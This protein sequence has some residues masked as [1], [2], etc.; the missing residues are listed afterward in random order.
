MMINLYYGRENLNKEQFLF[1]EIKAQLAEIRLKKGACEKI[2]LLVPD[3]FTLQAERNAF[4]YLKIPGMLE[5]EITSISRLGA[6]ILKETGG[7]K[8]EHVD[9]YGRHMLLSQII[10]QEKENLLAF[11][12]LDQNQSFIK[13]MNNLISEMK[14]YNADPETILSIM[15]SLDPS[16]LLNKKLKDIYNIYDK[17]ESRLSGKQLD[18]EDYIS[19]YTEGIN[20]SKQLSKSKIWIFGFDYFTPKN[21]NVLEKL[22]LNTLEVNLIFC[23]NGIDKDKEND[24]EIFAITEEMIQR[25]IGIAEKCGIPC[26]RKEVPLSYAFL[27]NPFLSHLESQAFAYPHKVYGSPNVSK[28]EGNEKGSAERDSDFPI[29][30]CVA[31]N[32]YAE[33]ESVAQCIRYLIRVKKLRYKD[34]L[35]ICNDMETRGSVLKRVF[36]QYEIGCFFDVKRDILHHPQIQLLLSLMDLMVYGWTHETVFKIF[37]T[38]LFLFEA[39]DICLLENYAKKYRLIRGK[40]KNPLKYGLEDLDGETS[41]KLEEMRRTTYQILHN[42]EQDFKSAKKASQKTEILVDF[43]QDCL[44]SSL[45]TE[46]FLSYLEENH[47]FDF[48]LETSQ[49]WNTTIN[50]FNQIVNLMGEE[51]ITTN[52]YA[53]LLRTGF[54]DVE[55][56]IIPP[57]LDE[58]LVGTAQRTRGGRV[59]A[60]LIL[61]ANDGLL[62]KI[63]SEEGLLNEDEKSVIFFQ[64]REICKVDKLRVMEETL[65]I[66]K[67]LAKPEQFLWMSY[68][69]T[70]ME[71]KE[72]KPCLLFNKIRGIFPQI[73]PEK[74]I[75]NSGD[76]VNLIGTP[77]STLKHLSFALRQ[78]EAFGETKEAWAIA[79]DWYLGKE[80]NRGILSPLKKGLA[81]FDSKEKIQDSLA[82][83]LY[84]KESFSPSQLEKYAKCPFSYFMTYGLKP[85][86][87]EEFRVTGRDMGDIYHRVLMQATQSLTLEEYPITG[88]ES[89]WMKASQEQCR[90]LVEGLL[91]KETH[92][93]KGGLLQQGGE[94]KYRM[95]RMK[96]VCGEALW[97]L[98]GQV[99]AGSIEK[100]YFEAKFGKGSDGV[101]PPISLSA[102]G[103]QFTIEGKIDRVDQ[104]QGSY[105]KIIDYKSG[106]EKFSLKEARA[107]LKLQ[108]LL[109]LKATRM[110][111]AGVFYFEI[112]ETPIDATEIS[113]EE[114]AG[115]VQE[116]KEK[117]YKLDGIVLDDEAIIESIAGEFSGYSQILQVRKTKEGNYAGTNDE[118]ILTEEEFQQLGEEVM[119]RVTETCHDLSTGKIYISPAKTNT[120]TACE[121]CAF[122]GV[123]IFDL[124]FD[125]CSY[126]MIK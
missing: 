67:I 27:T 122:G 47:H 45:K 20:R 15:E 103:K 121:F 90:E 68:S 8:R 25:I 87:E 26:K 86:E 69:A 78:G 5:L 30:L 18:T 102:D 91:E 77:K 40:W 64:G 23:H 4:D 75:Q 59:K 3:Q 73:V 105:A 95:N 123:C 63:N 6:K 98:V 60:L 116:E 120:T 62:P 111:P 79:L 50:I 32:I 85:E 9:Q 82:K 29:K 7:A 54:E 38:G 80:E 53:L 35:V 28:V 39:E 101:F 109:Y 118:R 13:M 22:C 126:N 66:Y 55:I 65:A 44:E 70:D 124:A 19:L 74:D 71:G 16:S 113:N 96:E 72:S 17:Y 92:G 99:R 57:T 97:A 43:L 76:P 81:P 56:G 48:A 100:I 106:K 114:Y 93:Y 108:L 125:G 2:L 14:Q 24:Q 10:R 1:D 117:T 46:A 83:E 49:V 51:E 115:K 31:A 33:A 21:L 104:L 88:E 41:E 52:E 61:G 42:L 110:K 36:D 107:G 84:K 58:V 112:G 12:G 34:I 94:E 37:K 11:Q 119:E 89:P